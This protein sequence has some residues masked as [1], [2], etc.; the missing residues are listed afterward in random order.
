MGV[1]GIGH[2]AA[3]YDVV[4]KSF[5]STGAKF[6]IRNKDQI[7]KVVGEHCKYPVFPPFM[8][9]LSETNTHSY[10]IDKLSTAF[11]P[12]SSFLNVINKS[13]NPFSLSKG[14]LSTDITISI[15]GQIISVPISSLV[16]CG[17]YATSNTFE[18]EVEVKDVGD[19]GGLLFDFDPTLCGEGVEIDAGNESDWEYHYTHLLFL[20]AQFV[21]LG[22]LVRSEKVSKMVK[23]TVEGK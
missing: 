22:C 11:T 13:K 17:K 3:F 6:L 2:G 14:E 23:D 9:T 10:P 12:D 20:I 7:M 21:L 16:H 5:N 1:V 19:V 15:R 18:C 4:R 8:I